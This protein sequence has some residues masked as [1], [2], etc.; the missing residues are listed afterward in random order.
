VRP[1]LALAPPVAHEWEARTGGARHIAVCRHLTFAAVAARSHHGG[2]SGAEAVAGAAAAAA[3]LAGGCGDGLLM[4]GPRKA[5]W[6][7]VR[8]WDL[9]PGSEDLCRTGTSEFLGAAVSDS[10]PA[11]AI[12][13]SP[14][15]GHEASPRA[16]AALE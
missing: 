10:G 4:P 2:L 8:R 14:R 6:L 13:L 12:Q 16:E 7:M 9:S 3:A 1:T 15:R 5:S 11:P